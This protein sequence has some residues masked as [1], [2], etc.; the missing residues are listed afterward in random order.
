MNE[1][2]KNHRVI[3]AAQEDTMHTQQAINISVFEILKINKHILMRTTAKKTSY[4]ETK[5]KQQP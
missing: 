3:F 1:W 4:N 2:R 5:K